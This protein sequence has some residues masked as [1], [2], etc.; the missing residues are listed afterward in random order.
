MKRIILTLTFMICLLTNAYSQATSLTVDCQNPG[1]LS[2]MINYGDQLTLK[3]IKVSGYLNGT[4]LQFIIDMNKKHSLTGTIDLEWTSIVSGGTLNKYPYTVKNDNVLPYEV[5]QGCN[6]VQKLVLPNTLISPDDLGYLGINGDSLIWTSSFMNSICVNESDIFN[7]IHLPDGVKEINFNGINIGSEP[8][9]ELSIYLPNSINRISGRAFDLI[10]FSLINDPNI[11][12]AQEETYDSFNGKRYWTPI[13][14]SIFY[15]PKGSLEKYQNS[16]FNNLK[17]IKYQNG[18]EIIGP[19]NNQFIEYY[20]ID[21]TI[22]NSPD[23]FYI[24]DSIPLSVQIYPDVKFVSWIDYYSENPEILGV[25]AN[26]IVVGN[27]Y[28][29]AKVYATPHLFIDGIKTK[30]GSCNINVLAHTEGIDMLSSMTVHINE[31]KALDAKTLP[32]GISDNRIIYE[33]Q[34]PSIAEVTDDGIVIGNNRGICTITATTVDGGYQAECTVKVIQP[35]ETIVLDR[36]DIS[37]KVGE[38]ERLYANISP[39]TA[40]DKNVLWLSSDIQIASVDNNGNIT[41]I[42]SGEAWI[43]AISND[44][45]KAND[46]CKVTVIQP[47]TGITISQSNCTLTGIGESVQLDAYVQPE[48][49]SNKEVRWSSSNDAI[50]VVSQGKVIATGFG[51]AVVIVSSVDGGFMDSCVVKVEDTSA[52]RETTIDDLDSSPIY[53]LMGCKVK[54]VTRGRLYIQNGQKYIAK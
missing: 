15:I 38:S 9:R 12:A 2:S 37:L 40:D 20:D 41:A 23:Y 31:R 54:K 24:G 17:Q 30:T 47:V 36:H 29:S 21:S 53:D 49:A 4:D 22:V 48:D 13:A 8:D 10:I 27:N 34:D 28:G 35:V 19:S 42:K 18:T 16:D 44:N 43:R 52:I 45:D 51:T 33:S 5:F 14:N 32:I 39:E 46:S 50:C 1:W 6:D 26:G 3:N 25:N 11:V 7:Y